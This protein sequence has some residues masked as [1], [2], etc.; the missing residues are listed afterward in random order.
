V[1]IGKVS[2]YLR[3]KQITTTMTYL[4]ITTE[5]IQKELDEVGD[6]ILDIIGDY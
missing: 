2:K 1:T 4:K 6:P 3:H 5:D